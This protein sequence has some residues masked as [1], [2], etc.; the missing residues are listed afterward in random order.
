MGPNRRS[1]IIAPRRIPV[2]K[3]DCPEGGGQAKSCAGGRAERARRPASTQSALRSAVRD[4][5]DIRCDH[6]ILT[7][8]KRIDDTACLPDLAV[9]SDGALLVDELAHRVGCFRVRHNQDCRTQRFTNIRAVTE[10]ERTAGKILGKS[11]CGQPDVIPIST[12]GGRTARA[13]FLVGLHLRRRRPDRLILRGRSTG[14]RQRRDCPAHG[15]SATADRSNR[16]GIRDLHTRAS[17]LGS[18]RVAWCA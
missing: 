18:S 4:F 5:S 2:W 13:E 17:C 16:R 12:Q 7:V 1:R 14:A 3:F 9:F 10:L 8:S 6:T 15:D 11:Y